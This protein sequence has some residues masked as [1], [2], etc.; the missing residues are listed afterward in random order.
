MYNTETADWE[1]ISFSFS[2]IMNEFKSGF[3]LR[4]ILKYNVVTLNKTQLPP[5]V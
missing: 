2:L 1:R 5:S 4:I 3:A